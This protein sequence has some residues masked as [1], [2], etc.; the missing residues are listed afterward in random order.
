MQS[1]EQDAR[2]RADAYRTLIGAPDPVED[3]VPFQER[4]I[5]AK[6]T[7]HSAEHRLAERL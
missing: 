7:E 6:A 4:A 1:P 2:N 3:L 5:T